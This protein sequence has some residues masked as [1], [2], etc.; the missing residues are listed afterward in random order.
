[1]WTAGELAEERQKKLWPDFKVRPLTLSL[2]G[3]KAAQCWIRG[4]CMHKTHNENIVHELPGK[5]V[6]CVDRAWNEQNE[7]GGNI[8]HE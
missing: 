8:S 4:G 2:Q 3:T 5:M 6:G 1:M 7:S